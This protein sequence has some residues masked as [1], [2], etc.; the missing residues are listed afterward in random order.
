[1]YNMRTEDCW[2]LIQNIYDGK[3]VSSDLGFLTF[4]SCRTA[5]RILREDRGY[6]TVKR[7][8]PSGSLKNVYLKVKNYG[9]PTEYL[10]IGEL[11]KKYMPRGAVNYDEFGRDTDFTEDDR[12][13]SKKEEYI[14][15]KYKDI[16][17]VWGIYDNCF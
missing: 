5:A 4:D 9:K 13:Y 16:L 8:T 1:M 3:S 15:T 7:F 10:I 14:F 11:A 12:P 17:T 6:I 2:F